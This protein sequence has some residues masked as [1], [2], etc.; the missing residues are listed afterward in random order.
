MIKQYNK[1]VEKITKEYL[2]TLCL[3][4]YNEK[5]EDFD[6]MD[7]NWVL[8]WPVNFSDMY[9]NLDDI[10]LAYRHKIPW[11]IFLDYNDLCLE[12]YENN[13]EPWINLFNYWRKQ[14]LSP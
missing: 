10:I 7:Y 5:L 3:E 1:I 4:L 9:F 11:K 2:N 8:Q 12:C 13:K 14:V 6:I